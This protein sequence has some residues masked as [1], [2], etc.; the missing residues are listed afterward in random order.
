[1]SRIKNGQPPTLYEDGKQTRDFV[2]V[3]DIAQACMLCLTKRQ[4]DQQIFNVGTGRATSIQELAERL[5]RIFG[6]KLKPRILNT[7]RKG[8]IRHCYADIGRIQEMLGYRPKIELDHGMRELIE[9]AHGVRAV[10]R[11]DRAHRE[12]KKHGLV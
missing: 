4:A 10:D 9:W 2:S 6:A 5:I 11:F 7:F 12:L 1:M 8:D 3:H